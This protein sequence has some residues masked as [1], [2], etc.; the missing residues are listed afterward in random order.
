M[1][2]VALLLLPVAI[3]VAI[4][5]A[6]FIVL[7]ESGL[8]AAESRRASSAR[9]AVVAF[10]ARVEAVLGPIIARVDGVRRGQFEATALAEELTA[11]TE[12]TAGLLSDAE[13][14]SL[15]AEL[16][17]VRAGITEELHR[18]ERA[19]DM[20]EH[21]RSI[22]ASARARGREI[23]AQTAVKRGYL[24]LLHAREAIG[25]YAAR[26]AAYRTPREV[27]RQQRRV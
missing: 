8:V 16:G 17:E 15:P 21:G 22:M 24:N 20:V 14:L 10:D 6:S 9:S 23:E 1:P 3:G 13:A 27:R 25:R 5:A 12:A 18:A 4:A 11:A 7:R 26:A 2:E 19:L